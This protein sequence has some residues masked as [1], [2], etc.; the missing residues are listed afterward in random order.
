MNG[1]AIEIEEEKKLYKIEEAKL[2]YIHND[3]YTSHIHTFTQIII[4]FQI[5]EKLYRAGKISPNEV[6][7]CLVQNSL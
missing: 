2:V 7:G 4:L 5:L 6:R 3:Q 1:V